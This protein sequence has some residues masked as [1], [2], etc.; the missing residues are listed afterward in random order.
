MRGEVR[1]IAEWADELAPR[2]ALMEVS[3][4]D[5]V[6]GREPFQ[7]RLELVSVCERVRKLDAACSITGLPPPFSAIREGVSMP[8]SRVGLLQV[9]QELL[10][11]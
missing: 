5:R 4:L 1:G 8:I 3:A 10:A 7:N 11:T 6:Y 9:K 2:G